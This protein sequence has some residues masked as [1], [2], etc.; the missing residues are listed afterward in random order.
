LNDDEDSE[1]YKLIVD[2]LLQNGEYYSDNGD[3][4]EYVT[5]ETKRILKQG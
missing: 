3:D 1:T 5:D 4:Q 2:Q